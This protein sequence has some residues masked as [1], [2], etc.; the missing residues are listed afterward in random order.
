M[1]SVNTV[2]RI[3]I[4]LWVFFNSMDHQLNV[5]L[6]IVFVLSFSLRFV[7]LTVAVFLI[8]SCCCCLLRCR[9]VAQHESSNRMSANALAIVFAPCL[10][11]RPPN[12]QTLQLLQLNESL[13][14]IQ[15]QTTSVHPLTPLQSLIPSLE[16][17]L[18][19]ADAYYSCPPPLLLPLPP[20]PT[21]HSTP[22]P[23][24]CK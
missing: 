10:M 20:P 5:G 14:D 19:S 9:R 7:C 13:N 23:P 16:T 21:P 3:F 1:N 4:I 2:L 17:Q 22:S 24:F 12:Q 6:I 8:I 11:R 15:R 18:S